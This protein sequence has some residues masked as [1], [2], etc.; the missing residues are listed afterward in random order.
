MAPA[1]QIKAFTPLPEESQAINT[2]VAGYR[3]WR[4]GLGTPGRLDRSSFNEL[5][6]HAAGLSKALDSIY[7]SAIGPA[8][9]CFRLAELN[10][11]STA[12]GHCHAQ[13]VAARQLDELRVILPRLM[14]AVEA[15]CGVGV[16]IDQDRQEWTWRLA[17]EWS[18]IRDP[19]TDPRF[20]KAMQ[21]AAE[22]NKADFI[23]HPYE[24]DA[25]V[26]VMRIWVREFGR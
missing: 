17:N 20:R 25:F 6:K 2:A 4:I 16:L 3:G 8:R 24:K 9:L 23:P 15:E 1:R 22:A 19:M 5:R 21:Y 13:D 18:K 12:S 11:S 10:Q 26:E 14:R 7:Q